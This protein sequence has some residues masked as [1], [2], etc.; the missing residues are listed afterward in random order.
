[1]KATTNER[2]TTQALNRA[3]LA[4]Q[5][6]LERSDLPVVDVVESIGA[7]QAQYWPALPVGLWSRM[8]G[9]KAADLYQALEERRLVVGSLLRGTLHL[10][11]AREH[12]TYAMAVEGSR[13]PGWQRTEAPAAP[14][15]ETLRFELLAYAGTGPRSIE[16]V[17]E[18]IE[19][20]I[21][22]HP[23]A[24]H[25]SE[26]AVQRQFKWRPF[27]GWTA[28][29][30]TPVDGRW[31]PRTPAG[32][33]AGPCPP[34][35]W[36][37]PEQALET[38]IRCH[39]RA[40]GPAAAE[41][42]AAWI[43]WRTPPVRD[44]LERLGSRLVRFQDEAGRVLYDLPEAPR[45]GADVPAPLRLLPWFDSVLLAYAPGRRE[46]ILAAAHKDLVF[47]RAN[48][49]LLP[50]F[51]VDGLVAGTWSVESRRREARLRPRP[52]GRLERPV[53]AALLE[54][55]ERLLH[56]SYPSATRQV[57]IEG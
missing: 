51:L 3:L 10:V 35:A 18:F 8:G 25:E 45:P 32:Q 6:L 49:Q 27:R 37:H 47:M 30:R 38:V 2:L 50:T 54:E 21:A 46:R 40:F 28:L 1:M 17:V 9:F 20:W 12:P 34:P 43:G 16:D 31:G 57:V 5:G 24:L 4:R 14:E 41:D 53:R 39:L 44:S 36:P 13:V 11:S 42:V 33:T 52:F 23:G 55:A 56:F 48:M 19:G 26:L 29:V 7:L 15:I 22:R